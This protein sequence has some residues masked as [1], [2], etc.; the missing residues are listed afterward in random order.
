MTERTGKLP[1][2]TTFREVQLRIRES[3]RNPNVGEVFQVALK[4]GPRAFK[5]ATVF[6]ILDPK[7]GQLHHHH[8]R[9]DHI[10]RKKGGWFAK[11]EK[12][13][14][15][16]DEE[17]DKLGLFLAA[18]NGGHLTGRSGDLHV[19]DAQDYEQLANL[20]GAL[21]RL[22]AHDRLELT[23]GLLSRFDGEGPSLTEFVKVFETA[24]PDLTSTI[25][26]AARLVEYEAAIA[27][28][29]EL[30]ENPDTKEAALQEHLGSNSWMFGSEYSQLLE[31]RHWTRDDNLDYM[32]RRTVDGF[33]EIVEIKRANVAP[34]FNHDSSHDSY[35][36]AASLSKV[37]GQT[38]RYIG[39]TER[40]RDAILAKDGEE[41]LK[42]RARIII[43]RDGDQDQLRS[44]KALNAH[45]NQ[46]EIMT[47]DQLVRVARRVVAVFRE[48][49]APGAEE[50]VELP[51]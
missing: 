9:M 16:D 5:I 19:V 24:R 18:L 38:I 26:A 39:E 47:F 7:T 6:E 51:F 36:P 13:F 10:D 43:G 40:Q 44:L 49:E 33:L 17:I 41:T 31:R 29:E 27:K 14:R 11:P 22:P 8:L 28:L 20:L 30:I 23:K 4:E 2:D 34:L 32:L 15:C 35:Y 12:S 46:I 37:I 48:H 25:A 3:Y 45:L 1:A 21:D 42:V 50:E